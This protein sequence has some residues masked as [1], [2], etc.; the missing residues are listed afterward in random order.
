MTDEEIA[1]YE[2]GEFA[3]E[4]TEL[5][6]WDDEAKIAGLKTKG[7]EH[8]RQPLIAALQL[9]GDQSTGSGHPPEKRV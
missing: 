7:W 5:R 2:A 3:R 8:F 9:A 1:Q 6:G 4:A